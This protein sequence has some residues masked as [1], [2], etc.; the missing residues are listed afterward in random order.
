ML[1]LAEHDSARDAVVEWIASGPVRD[2]A[3]GHAV[4]ASRWDILSREAGVV[5]GLAQWS[6]RLARLAR[7]LTAELEDAG[8]DELSEAARRHREAG[9]QH[10][11]HPARFV[12]D[13]RVRLTAPPPGPSARP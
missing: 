5:T 11:P 8:D 4:P 13:L 6:D 9:L 7:R 12:T 3:D 2:P 10:A 1:R